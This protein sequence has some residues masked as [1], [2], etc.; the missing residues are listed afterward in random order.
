MALDQLQ[1]RSICAATSTHIPE[2]LHVATNE[3]PFADNFG[4]EG[5]S[6]QL[7]QADVE[8]S[9]F[10]VR[11]RFAPG[12]QLPPHHHTGLVFAYTLSGEWY[13]LEYQDSTKNRA[14]SYMY[15]PPGSLH[16]LKISDHNEELTDVIFVIQGAMLILDDE[17]RVI[18]VLD[19]ASHIK[20]WSDALKEQGKPVPEIITGGQI[21]YATP[22]E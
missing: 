7:I 8:A 2:A 11:I 18:Q 20:D 21:G 6:L 19:A 12:V 3:R 5:V 13:Y 22:G 10:T 1:A 14:G 17:G 15:E 16:T 4:M 9:T